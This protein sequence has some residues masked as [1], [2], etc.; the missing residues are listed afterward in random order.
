MWQGDPILIGTQSS[1]NL[2]RLLILVAILEGIIANTTSGDVIQLA[3][4]RAQDRCEALG[5]DLDTFA[6]VVTKVGMLGESLRRNNPFA[7]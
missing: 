4:F 5:I 6:E 7:F 1:E 3:F 2:E